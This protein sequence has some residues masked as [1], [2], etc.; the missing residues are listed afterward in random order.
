MSTQ[1]IP[2]AVVYMTGA[3]G[4]FSAMAVAGREVS[5]ELDTFEIMM[6]RSF[7]GIAVVL[8]LGVFWHIETH[9]TAAC[10]YPFYAQSSTFYGAESV[11]LCSYGDPTYTT[12]CTGIYEPAVGFIAVSHGLG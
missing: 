11:V 3:I 8:V 5:F 12:F 10:G 1:N 7:V 6:Y 9:H 2:K 4:S